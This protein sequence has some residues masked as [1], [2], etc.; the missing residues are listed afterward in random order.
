MA[1]TGV[2]GSSA[3]R[4]GPDDFRTIHVPDK[5]QTI[6]AGVDEAEEG[7]LVLVEPGPYPESIGVTTPGITIRGTDR[8]EVLLD[9]AFERSYGVRIEAD[10]VAVENVTARHYQGTP[11][12]WSHVT[13]FRGSYLT[14]YNNGDYGIY[15]YRST[16]GRF[17]YSYASGHP[18]AGFYFGRNEPFEAV[19][20]DVVAEY[21]G[22]GYSG[23]ST[24]EGL[25]IENSV[26]R[27]NQA[28]IV[29]NTLDEIDPPQHSSHIVDNEVH[30]NGNDD[31]PHKALTYPAFGNGIVIWGGRDNLIEDNDVH[32]HEH[33]GIVVEP[34]VVEPTG[35]VVRENTVGGSGE[36]DLALGTPSGDDNRFEENEFETSLP[37]DIELDASAGAD[38]VSSVFGD[39]ERLASNDHVPGGDWRDQPVPDDQPTM[40]NP[41]AP[42]RP[43]DVTESWG[44]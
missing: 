9:G 2:V 23:T 37:E 18:D 17:E 27:Y 19:I 5:H 25:T 38:R 29:P 26:W 33:F 21:N 6:Q 14:A 7:D 36:A 4:F 13:G 15:A 32:D 22:L 10:G 12:Y 41:E 24:G 16:D 20:T 28:G 11:F 34:N 39:L 30:D 42:P 40:P 3:A 8:N 43:V 44:E 31:A 35:N 1:G